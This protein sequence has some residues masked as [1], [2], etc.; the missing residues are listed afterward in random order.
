MKAAA[1]VMGVAFLV[2]TGQSAGT[3]DKAEYA[4]RRGRLKAQA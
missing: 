1:V 4:A 2:A 3:F